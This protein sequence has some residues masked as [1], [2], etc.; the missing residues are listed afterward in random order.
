MQSVDGAGERGEAA[1]G[2]LVLQYM[3]VILV[4]SVLTLLLTRRLVAKVG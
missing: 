3:L 2:V 4:S 1:V